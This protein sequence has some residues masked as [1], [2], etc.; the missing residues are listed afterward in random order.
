MK[1]K[2]TLKMAL[3]IVPSA[4]LWLTIVIL[5]LLIKATYGFYV[6]LNTKV[7]SFI[8]F[9]YKKLGHWVEQ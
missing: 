3:G 9:M 7:L 2:S 8:E 6:L 4:F 1:Q 5:G